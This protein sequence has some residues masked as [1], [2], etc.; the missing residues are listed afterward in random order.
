MPVLFSTA[1]GR[2]ESKERRV[3]CPARMTVRIYPKKEL[4]V[5]SFHPEIPHLMR[6]AHKAEYPLPVLLVFLFM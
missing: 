6:N 2:C 3:V 1:R 4:M 5:R